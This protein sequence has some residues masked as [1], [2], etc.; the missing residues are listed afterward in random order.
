M[1]DPNRDPQLNAPN[2]NLG[3]LPSCDTIMSA[4][5]REA[6]YVRFAMDNLEPQ[7]CQNLWQQINDCY[8]GVAYLK[9]DISLCA[10]VKN[11]VDAKDMCIFGVADQLQNPSLC[12][13]VQTESIKRECVSQSAPQADPIAPESPSPVTDPN[14]CPAKPTQLEKDTCYWGQGLQNPDLSTCEKIVNQDLREGCYLATAVALKDETIC[15]K[16][17]TER[18]RWGKSQCY[19]DV[20]IAKQDP[21]VCALAPTTPDA[22]ETCQVFA[23][24]Q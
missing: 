2:P 22:I 9:K 3:G 14:D 11:S 21:S 23:N 15:D 12:D 10:H 17:T 18:D 8:S 1:F 7:W 19:F 13:S 24:P 20:A 16:M 6:C 4:Q 5:D